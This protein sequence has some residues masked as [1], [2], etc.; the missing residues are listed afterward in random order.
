MSANPYESPEN[1]GQPEKPA[2]RRGFR[3]IELLVVVG[4]IGLMIACLLPNIRFGAPEAGRRISCS[5]NLKQIAL[6]L[7]LYHDVYECFPPACTVDEEGKPLH[8]W[9]TLILPFCDQ[10]SPYNKIELSKPWD[11][12]ANQAA[13]ETNIR[14]Y[15]CA[16]GRLPKLQTTYC[17]VTSPAGCFPGAES[18][19]LAEI[20][21]GTDQTIVVIEVPVANAVHWMSP[22]DVT[23]ESFLKPIATDKPPHLSG[24]HVACADGSILFLPADTPQDKLR[25][26]LS[27][28]GNDDAE[29]AD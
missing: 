17:V 6:A 3:L 14:T 1:P 5:N 12:P 11:D 27:I 20:T 21:D 9:R 28:A 8:S 24:A 13:Y 22:R 7:Q 18:R 15:Q 29:L 4:L 23:A 16:S 2:G 25:A 19:K 10:E 26:L